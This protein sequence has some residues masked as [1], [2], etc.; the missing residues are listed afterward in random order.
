MAILGKRIIRDTNGAVLVEVTVMMTIMFV[1]VL[2]MI[3]FLF[4]FYQWNMAAKAAEIGARIAA[5]SAPVATGLNATASSGPVEGPMPTFTVVCDGNTASCSGCSAPVCTGT[6]YNSSA[7][8]TI[9]FG[10]GS[11]SCADGNSYYL[12]GMCDIF[13]R[14]RP[15]NVKITYTSTGM[16]FPGRP[17]G[18]VP[19]I[20]VELQGLQFEYFF[21]GGLLSFA[22]ISIPPVTT[23]ITGEDLCSLN[24]C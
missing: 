22:N 14:I 16:G 12:I 6:S 21:L 13:Y 24:T 7:M 23:T 10:R 17:G 3:D 2:G 19:T 9:I 4:A 8:N 5:V 1:F 20:T 11:A 18:V 15:E